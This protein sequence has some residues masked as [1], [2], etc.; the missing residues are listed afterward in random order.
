M[1][2]Q[3]ITTIRDDINKILKYSKKNTTCKNLNLNYS[4]LQSLLLYSEID[5]CLEIFNKFIVRIIND[6][7]NNKYKL[8]DLQNIEINF[9]NCN[10]YVKKEKYNKIFPEFLNIIIKNYKEKFT[11]KEYQI[12]IR[13]KVKNYK[14]RLNHIIISPTGTGKTVIFSIIICDYILKNKKDV[15]ILTKKKEI[16]LDLHKRIE[17]YISNFK[18]NNLIFNLQCEIQNCVNDCSTQLLNKKHKNTQIYIVNWD[19]FT[20]SAST[21]ETKVDWNKFGLM[22]IDESH[23]VSAD[24]ISKVMNY[25]KDETKI[26]YLGFSA[27][28]IRT[29][30]EKQTTMLNIFN[31]NDGDY[32]VLYEHTYYKALINKD[33][34]PIKYSPIEINK[35]DL[36]ENVYDDKEANNKTIQY[37]ILSPTAYNKVW[38]QLNTKIIS[39]THFKKGIFWFRARYDMLCFYNNMKNKMKDF[40]IFATMTYGENTKSDT[41]IK[42]VDKKVNAQVK[43]SGLSKEHFDSAIIDFKAEGENAILLAVMR[44]TEGFDDDKLEFGA[45]MFYSNKIDPLNESQR[46]GRFN[47]WHKNNNKSDG[48]KKYGYFSSLELGDSKEELKK[49][50]IQRFRSWIAFARINATDSFEISGTKSSTDTI[51][52]IIELYV[53]IDTLKTYDIDIQADIINSIKHLDRDRFVIKAVLKKYNESRP[54]PINTRSSYNNWA[55]LNNFPIADELEAKEKIDF[56]WLFSLTPDDYLSFNE[57]KKLAKEYKSDCKKAGNNLSS[58]QMYSLMRQKNTLVPAE[59]ERFYGKLYNNVSDL[60]K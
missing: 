45:R 56:N 39:K 29:N 55:I 10:N 9:K 3:L 41:E 27:T 6:L 22:I 14:E 43:K 1:E 8:E 50:L 34:C 16:L 51:Y 12:E 37:K 38:E 54:N 46:M 32:N 31:N 7:D 52:K 4:N 11:L 40:K 18:Q 59:P 30:R 19:K 20:S 23:W 49:S 57:L 26:N 33:I 28:P 17:E 42:E 21:D 47:R 24:A 2:N 60:F 48:L 5:Y 13:N 35:D 36:I 25:I 53:D 58:A 44:C 15:I